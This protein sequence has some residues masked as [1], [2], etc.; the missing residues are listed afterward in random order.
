MTLYILNMAMMSRLLLQIS[1]R[2]IL[3]C[4]ENL[5]KILDL[6]NLS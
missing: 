4:R 2:H 5:Y 3:D 6:E 1:V